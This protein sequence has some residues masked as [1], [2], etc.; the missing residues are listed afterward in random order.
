MDGHADVF[1][2]FAIAVEK[3]EVIDASCECGFGF[4]RLFLNGVDDVLQSFLVFNTFE[5]QLNAAVFL[6]SR[7]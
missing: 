4:D 5:V 7:G 1:Y 6:Q 3:A 2:D